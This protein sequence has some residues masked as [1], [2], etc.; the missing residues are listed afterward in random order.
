MKPLRFFAP[1]LMAAALTTPLHTQ[2]ADYKIDSKG[3]HASINFQIPHL[4][5]SI[6]VGRFNKFEGK[7]TYDLNNVEASEIE[8]LVDTTSIDSN[9]AER[10]KHLRSDDY[11]DTKKFGTAKFVSTKVIDRGDNQL[12]VEGNL[13]LHGVTKPITIEAYKVGEGPDPWM[14]YRAGFSGKTTLK[15]QDFG[16]PDKLGPA[17]SRVTLDLHIEGIRQ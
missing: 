7:F 13:T 2:A 9:H 1:I 17:S 11:L 6:L 8:V 12:L 4:G 14:G 5:Y 3:A 10:D 16:I 15:L